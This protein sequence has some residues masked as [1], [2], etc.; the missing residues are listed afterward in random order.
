MS[1]DDVPLRTFP[2]HAPTQVPQPR[3]RRRRAAVAAPAAHGGRPRAALRGPA[4]RHGRLPGRGE[5][6]L[7]LL[8]L[9]LL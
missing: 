7:L 3:A 4:H 6:P 8:L 1:C 9:L 5:L 2:P